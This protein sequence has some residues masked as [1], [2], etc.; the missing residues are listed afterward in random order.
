MKI[1]S[2]HCETCDKDFPLKKPRVLSGRERFPNCP[3]CGQALVAPP[4][5]E[6]VVDLGEE[7]SVLES[8]SELPQANNQEVADV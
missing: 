7:S 8:E 6:A 2:L 3:H 5:Q 4:V 1:S